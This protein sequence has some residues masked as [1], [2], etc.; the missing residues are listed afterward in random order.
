MSPGGSNSLP[1]N[2]GDDVYFGCTPIYTHS[3]FEKMGIGLHSENSSQD[4]IRELV[5]AEFDS[6]D[7]IKG[8]TNLHVAVSPKKYNWYSVHAGRSVSIEYIADG[9]PRKKSLWIKTVS[10]PK[11]AYQAI[12]SIHTIAAKYDIAEPI[13]KPYFYDEKNKVLCMEMI[14]GR[15]LLKLTLKHGICL[16]LRSI[17]TLSG[18]FY[19]IGQW[20]HK[21][22]SSIGTGKVSTLGALIEQVSAEL[23]TNMTF[24]TLEKRTI[25]GTL[26]DIG[27]T[28][29]ADKPFPLVRPH[30]DFTLRNLFVGNNGGFYVLDWD[31][32]IHPKC[33]NEALCWT[34]ITMLILNLQSMLRIYPIIGRNRIRK[35]CVAL[36]NGYFTE[37]SMVVNQTTPEEFF[38]HILYVFAIKYWL[39]FDNYLP[40]HKIYE[41]HGG[42]RYAEKL[43]KDLLLGRADITNAY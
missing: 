19:G 24:N 12:D 10:T 33:P 4:R 25:S 1:V 30:N 34:D 6:I 35:L 40:M 8:K 42:W 29:I 41:K 43:R 15:S 23:H 7:A 16:N 20:M 27:S 31:M 13:P 3:Y 5:C 37:D 28:N 11:E 32:M 22:H 36:L 9:L 38:R 14:T 39:G 21:Y 17:N 2:V 26:S 18:I